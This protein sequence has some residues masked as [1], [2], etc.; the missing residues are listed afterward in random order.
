MTNQ[1]DIVPHL[2]PEF[3][4]FAHPAGEVHV[5]TVDEKSGQATVLACPGR[6][7]ESCIDDGDIDLNVGDHGGTSFPSTTNGW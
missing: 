4:G 2:P 5:D 6:D 7:N 1:N 3:V